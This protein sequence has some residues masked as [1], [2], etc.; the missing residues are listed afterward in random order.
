MEIYWV[1]RST[2][3]HCRLDTVFTV[4]IELQSK[5]KLVY[6][7]SFKKPLNSEH[8][9]PTIMKD[10]C[11]YIFLLIHNGYFSKDSMTFNMIWV[12]GRT[13]RGQKGE[14]SPKQVVFMKT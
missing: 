9:D 6:T 12:K 3:E 5:E 11:L 1:I 8:L 10:E 2:T 13:A 7:D 14:I 4:F